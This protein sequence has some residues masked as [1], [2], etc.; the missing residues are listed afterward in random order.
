[1]IGKQYPQLKDNPASRLLCSLEGKS[2]C[3][4]VF[5]LFNLQNHRNA[6]LDEFNNVMIWMTTTQLEQYQRQANQCS[7]YKREM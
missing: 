4:Q 3:V 7:K 1:M 2:D 6:L 5:R